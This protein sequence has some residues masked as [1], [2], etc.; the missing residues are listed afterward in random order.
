MI[1]LFDL[2]Y[3]LLDTKRFKETHKEPEYKNFDKEI[4]NYLFP[5]TEKT[6][7]YLK[8]QGHK[9]ILLTLG[10]PNF[11]K[12]KV[13]NSKIK[14][15]FEKIVYEPKNKAENTLLKDLS[16]GDEDI[17]IIN[18]K[19]EE[20]NE[21]QKVLGNKSKIFLVADEGYKN[22]SELIDFCQKLS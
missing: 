3:T 6:L 16:M 13:D 12:S 17:I 4:N 22:I 8:N 9:L 21:M 14:K 2:D 1:L 7:S 15:Y 11:Q 5:E 19:K 10:E 20:S 18:D